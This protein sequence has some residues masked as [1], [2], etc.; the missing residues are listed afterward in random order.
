MNDVEKGKKVI[1]EGG[2]VVYPTDTLYGLGAS[3]FKENAVKKVYEIK[4]RPYHLPLSIIVP[5]IEKIEEVA[6]VT[7]LASTLAKNFLPGALTL[8][9]KKKDI[10]P[11]IVAK[12]KIGVR[13]PDNDVARKLASI[14]PITATSANIHGGDEPV[15]IEISKKQLGNK[16]DM[17]I[18]G[19]KL[20]GIPSTIVDVT[21]EEL[22]IIREGV[23]QRER[24]YGAL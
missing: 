8:V 19:G 18:D 21:G 16:V 13:I 14:E 15:T 6:I 11:D 4:K 9:L 24:L 20:P 1:K 10:I 23:I 5:S 7:E 22:K 12:E 17:Y 2:I 3:V